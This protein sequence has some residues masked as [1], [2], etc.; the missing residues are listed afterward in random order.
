[1]PPEVEKTRGRWCECLLY[2]G[3][4]LTRVNCRMLWWIL[5]YR[6]VSTFQQAESFLN[7]ICANLYGRH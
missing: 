6:R 7:R 2:A 5:K 1:M 4:F 3:T